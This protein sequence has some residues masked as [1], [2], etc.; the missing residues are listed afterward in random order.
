MSLDEFDVLG[1]RF[2]SGG[3]SDTTAFLSNQMYASSKVRSFEVGIKN[4]G[5]FKNG[6]IVHILVSDYEYRFMVLNDIP[7]TSVT[8]ISRMVD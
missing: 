8:W 1:C 5:T 2:N 6:D 7:G 3:D 4:L